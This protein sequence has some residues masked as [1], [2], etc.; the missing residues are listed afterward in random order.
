MIRSQRFLLQPT[1]VQAEY[2]RRAAGLNRFV[3]N[4]G[5]AICKRYYRWFGKRKGYKR[6]TN[7]TLHKRW[8][9]AKCRRFGWANDVSKHVA[10]AA[11]DSLELA[12]QAFFGK[13]GR[14]P[15]LKTKRRSPASFSAGRYQANR[16]NMLAFSGCRICLPKIGKVRCSRPPRWPGAKPLVARVKEQAGRWWLTVQYDLP[17][18]T[19]QPRTEPVAGLDLGCTTFATISSGGTIEEVA[20]PKPYAKA[21]RKLRRLQRVLSRRQKGSKRRRKAVLR[22]A[23]AHKRVADI[24][25]DFLHQLSRR[26][27]KKHG[28]VVLEDLSVK[29]MARG[30]LAGTIADL[31]FGEFRRQCEYKATEESA[32]VVVA[33][34]FYP[35]SKTCSGCGAVKADLSLKE[36]T[37]RCDACG[38]SIGRDINAARNLEALGRGTPEVTPVETGGSSVTARKPR[39]RSRK[40]ECQRETT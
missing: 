12:F 26:V 40:R 10:E 39:C 23:K 18:P 16:Q 5:L 37:Y 27:V 1:Q 21:K 8:V 19:P 11:L 6:P 17:D 22:V 38:L 25:T 3:Y 33:P 28:T 29:G 13:N 35:S 4:W 34:R 30:M 15:Q 14:Y 24:R 2:L 32:H 9:K 7:Y 20:P 31:G 36:R